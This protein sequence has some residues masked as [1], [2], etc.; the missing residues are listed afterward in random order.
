MT[1]SHWMSSARQGGNLPSCYWDSKVQASFCWF[2][3]GLPGV[4]HESSPFCPPNSISV[5]FLLIFI[6]GSLWWYPGVFNSQN[7]P[8][9]TTSD[10]SI[11]VQVLISWD[12]FLPC[13]YSRISALMSYNSVIACFSNL[14]SQDMLWLSFGS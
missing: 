7:C 4:P 3:K 5:R 2:C 10:Y 6:E 9:W 11:T 14:E 13:F 12:S 1:V 8:H